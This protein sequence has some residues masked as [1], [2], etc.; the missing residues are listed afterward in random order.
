MRRGKGKKQLRPKLLGDT[1]DLGHNMSSKVF[2][3]F[4]ILGASQTEVISCIIGVICQSEI[5]EELLIAIK[6]ISK[7]PLPK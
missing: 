4:P 3:F 2:V 1:L 7:S 5:R 6:T